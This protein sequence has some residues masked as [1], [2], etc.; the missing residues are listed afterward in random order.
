MIDYSWRYLLEEAGAEELGF[1]PEDLLAKEP[2]MEQVSL[3]G[4]N[5]EPEQVMVLV[6]A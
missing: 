6:M 2:V 1:W 4:V 3:Q 5:L